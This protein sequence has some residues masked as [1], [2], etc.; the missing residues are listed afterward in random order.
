[1]R[2]DEILSANAGFDGSK[3]SERDIEGILERSG[4]NDMKI[5]HAKFM[6]LSKSGANLVF[7]CLFIDDGS[8]GEGEKPEGSVFIGF[9]KT[10]KLKAEF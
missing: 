4:Y 2:L 3:L 7:K 8:F 5:K 1:M 10:G 9:D 6:G